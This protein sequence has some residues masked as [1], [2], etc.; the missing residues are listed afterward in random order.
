[1]PAVKAGFVFLPIVFL[2]NIPII[3]CD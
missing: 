3:H 1:N 2:L